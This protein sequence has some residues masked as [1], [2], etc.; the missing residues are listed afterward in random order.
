MTNLDGRANVVIL[1]AC[2][3]AP[4]MQFLSR[5][6]GFSFDEPWQAEALATTVHLGQQGLFS[7]KEWVDIFLREIA[8]E[9]QREDESV[10]NAYFR[11]WLAA[12]EK[13]LVSKGVTSATAMSETAEH[14]RR[15]YLNTEH[16]KPVQFSRAWREPDH[17]DHDEHDHHHHHGQ[18]TP[19][20]LAVSEG[21]SVN[22]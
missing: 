8:A 13:M 7:W 22:Q 17:H 3:V 1:S 19:S 11:Q 9:P 6:D 16:G 10:N 2:K 12:L 14:W 15:S 4:G 20:P 21:K 18:S 5:E